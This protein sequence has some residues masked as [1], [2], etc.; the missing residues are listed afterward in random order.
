MDRTYHLRFN[1]QLSAVRC[2]STLPNNC[3]LTVLGGD[4]FDPNGDGFDPIGD[5]CDPISDDCDPNS[6]DCDSIGD[7]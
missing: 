4:C 7:G 6:D 2:S 1:E 5:N 3:N